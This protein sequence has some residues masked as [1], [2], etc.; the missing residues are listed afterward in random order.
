MMTLQEAPCAV[1]TVKKI[2]GS[3]DLKRRM[4]NMGIA[5]GADVE[6]IEHTETVC[7]IKTVKREIELSVEEA[8]CIGVGEQFKRNG[9]PVLFSCLSYGRAGDLWD[10]ANEIN[11]N[12]QRKG[13]ERQ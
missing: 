11:E 8:A 1:Y 9:D 2:N 13:D 4:E 12:V 7:R 3:R 6:V 5:A 10:R